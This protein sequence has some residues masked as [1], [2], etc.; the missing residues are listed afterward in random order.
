MYLAALLFWF[1]FL[2]NT[3]P[4]T[5]T[6]VTTPASTETNTVNTIDVLQNEL[7]E[8]LVQ[9]CASEIDRN[10]TA[11]AI[12]KFGRLADAKAAMKNVVQ[13]YTE[14][15]EESFD[16]LLLF[17]NHISSLELQQI[18]YN[19]L[20]EAIDANQINVFNLLSF[21]RF[22]RT[23]F[24]L[25]NEDDIERKIY[26]DLLATIGN[27]VKEIIVGTDLNRVIMFINN[28]T[29]PDRIFELIPTIVQSIDLNNF[30]DM[31]R[32]F[33]FSMQLP[34]SNHI[35]LI[36]KVLSEMREKAQYQHVFHVISQIKL[37]RTSIYELE[38][39]TADICLLSS[40]EKEVPLQLRQL[41]G[42]DNRWQIVNYSDDGFLFFSESR[43]YAKT[44][45]FVNYAKLYY[46]WSFYTQ[47]MNSATII[48]PYS[49]RLLSVEYSFHNE[50]FPTLRESRDDLLQ[51]NWY[52]L[53]SN[54]L[55]YVQIKNIFT[56]DLLI[57]DDI[58]EMTEGGNTLPRVALSS[59]CP[60]CDS[61]KWL[62]K[63]DSEHFPK[64]YSSYNCANLLDTE[65]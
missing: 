42:D 32:I 3:N 4:I 58:L 7:N 57:A 19:T 48:N 56:N 34:T 50:S 37:L 60:D 8:I 29:T 24:E 26:E 47:S 36:S 65:D 6:A 43:K 64:S 63:F 55:T 41:L 27:H 53:M 18:A 11:S 16:N 17:V 22:I 23:K 38:W 20:V 15:Y 31:N 12:L 51:M 13:L 54:D 2:V 45:L 10:K 52:L 14:N 49:K 25:I 40:I 9:F 44:L 21:E 59:K 35:K 62:L 39:K 1:T 46:G 33:E 61:S 30:T 5:P 28:S